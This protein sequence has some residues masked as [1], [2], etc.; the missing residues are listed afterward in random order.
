MIICN[1][2]EGSPSRAI[3]DNLQ[4][5][6]DSRSNSKRPGQAQLIPNVQDI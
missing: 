6:N 2:G 4:I 3:L 1:P 5:A